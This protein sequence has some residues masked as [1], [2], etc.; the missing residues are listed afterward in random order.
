MSSKQDIVHVVAEI[1]L[2][3]EES[4]ITK[5]Q[6]NREKFAQTISFLSFH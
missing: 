5:P 2:S 6:L 3:M 4:E 1:Q